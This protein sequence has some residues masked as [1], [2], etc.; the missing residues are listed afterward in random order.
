MMNTKEAYRWEV[1]YMFGYLKNGLKSDPNLYTKA[2][3][4]V[5]AYKAGLESQDGT[6]SPVAFRGFCH[7]LWAGGVIDAVDVDEVDRLIAEQAA[8]MARAGELQTAILVE[9]IVNRIDV[10]WVR[11]HATDHEMTALCSPAL[12]TDA[13]GV[14]EGVGQVTCP[15]C[16]EIVKRCQAIPAADLTPEY[17]NELLA[18]KFARARGKA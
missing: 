16:V 10:A 17:E 1:D 5:C 14:V 12:H 8:S 2:Y 4:V 3:D 18:R 13:D 7:G 15:D 6:Y 9:R 11:T